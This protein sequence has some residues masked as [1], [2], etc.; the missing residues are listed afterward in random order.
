MAR[1]QF[2][3]YY[4]DRS[5]DVECAA[6]HY[7]ILDPNGLVK[8]TGKTNGQGMTEVVEALYDAGTYKLEVKNFLT[9][10]FEAPD[11]H[12]HVDDEPSVT[13]GNQNDRNFRTRKIRVKPYFKVQFLMAATNA[14]I[15]NAKFSAYVKSP[16]GKESVASALDGG[17]VTGTTK[18]D[19]HTDLIFCASPAV[20]K[21]EVPGSTVKPSTDKLRPHVKGQSP[22]RYEF[23]FKTSSVLTQPSVAAQTTLAGKKNLPLLISPSD[24]E[25]LMVPQDAFDEFE[26]F[27]GQLER[28]MAATHQAK[29]D[30]SRALEAG[31]K[32]EIAA[33][34]KALGLAEDKVKKELNSNFS[35]AT[36]LK[37]VITLESYQ[38]GKDSKTGAGQMGLRRRYLKTDRY[39]ELRNKRINKAE[40]KID[41]KFKGPAGSKASAS[42]SP[43]I[44]TTGSSKAPNAPKTLDVEALK[45]SFE[46]IKTGL[47]SAK[48]WKSEVATLDLIDLAGNELAES[49]VKSASY[50]V[51]AQAQWLRLVGCAG[52]NAEID[53][54]KKKAQVQGN[55][56]GKAV[57]CE[58][59]IT[60]TWAAPSLKGWMMNFLGEDLGAIRFVMELSAFG[61]VG[62]KAIATGAV[63]IT[64][65][66]GK[67]VA[68]AIQR[69]TGDKLSDAVPGKAG[70]LPRLN[71]AG[72]YEA[73]PAD[74][75]GVKA[76]ID[77][78]AGAEAGF[79]PAG[80]LQW[81]PP[82]EKDFVS[83]AEI[84]ATVAVS[85]G[86]G[87]QAAIQ[88]YYAGGKFKVKA[89]ARLCWGVGC[90]G[91]VEFTVNAEKI[92]Q[93]VEW[94]HYQLLH[95]GFRN[96]VYFEQRA[97]AALSQLLVVCIGHNTPMGKQVQAISDDVNRQFL[98]FTTAL[99]I[100]KERNALVNNVN[101]G[102][103]WLVHATPEAR[104]MLLYQITR[105]GTPSHMRDTP[106][107]SGSIV[108]PE[109]HF[110]ATH[111]QAVC[112]IM[113]TVQTAA[114]WDNVL[115]HMTE[116]GT[117]SS[118]AHGKNEGDVLRF[119]NN[120]YSLADL[121]EIFKSLNAALP[122]AA[123]VTAKGK[124]AEPPKATGNAYLDD[125]LKYRSQCLGEFPKGYKVA[126][127]DSA[128][129]EFLASQAGQQS[130]DFGEIRTAGL[131]EAFAGEAGSSVA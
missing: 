105:H 106:R 124:K 79:T 127:L 114:E 43:E 76:E 37:E 58:G 6:V 11:V 9:N 51:E 36:D 118:S 65:E 90:K 46:K 74:L 7:R 14:P 67:Q 19:G 64:L 57:L 123:K 23:H 50:E 94:V 38:K 21:F 52:A 99:D 126:A 20:F 49:I 53:W 56:Q 41:I 71:P 75:N 59:K 12:D 95:A 63:G 108:D 8:V 88:I 25:L 1:G 26:E 128:G 109:I 104:G 130:L 29:L 115:Q 39:M 54:V 78:F 103:A 31:T 98:G 81:L 110:L 22:C 4:K 70:G 129:F 91:A 87:A 85:A 72:A 47:K 102:P 121:P 10:K 30:L 77:A 97:F 13:L 125:F 60:G 113:K 92:L 33:A 111:K 83:F 96:L 16:Q 131:G 101:R 117:K 18:T 42:V 107:L 32:A 93:F 48:E 40:Y 45:K 28:V 17:S 116:R 61:F 82:Q 69:D 100:A 35:K 2:Q 3:L 84:S 44:K 119:L 80:K 89:A 120:G 5:A 34:E 62:A 66:G 24:N 122:Q 73:V 55:L 68:K 15:K 112:T 27:S 86:A